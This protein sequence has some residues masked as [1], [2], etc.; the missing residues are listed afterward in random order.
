MAKALG[1]IVAVV[2]LEVGILLRTIVP[3]ELQ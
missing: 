2:I 1:L 3:G